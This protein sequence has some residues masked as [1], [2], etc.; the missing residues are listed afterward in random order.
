MKIM[1]KFP[2][3]RH[4]VSPNF[5]ISQSQHNDQKQEIN[6][7]TILLTN[8]TDLIQILL[9]VPLMSIF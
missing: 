8:L 5:N 7:D 6:I 2:H 3:I 9:L 1:Q 4:P